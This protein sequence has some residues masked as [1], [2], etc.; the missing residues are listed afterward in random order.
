MTSNYEKAKEEGIKKLAEL[1]ILEQGDE[2][3]EEVNY[4]VLESFLS[5]FAEKIKEGVLE[6][7]KISF[8]KIGES[9]FKSSDSQTIKE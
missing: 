8:R 4:K 1:Q 9:G 7:V 2:L 6:D 5:S 3:W